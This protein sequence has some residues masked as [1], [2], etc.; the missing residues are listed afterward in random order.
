MAPGSSDRLHAANE[1]GTR[2]G[3]SLTIHAPR[4]MPGGGGNTPAPPMGDAEGIRQTRSPTRRTSHSRFASP[5]G[6]WCGFSR[7]PLS[8]IRPCAAVW[9]WNT[10]ADVP[11]CATIRRT[12]PGPAPC[13]STPG[14]AASVS[15]CCWSQRSACRKP[16]TDTLARAGFPASSSGS[17]SSDRSLPSAPGDSGRP[18]W[19]MRGAGSAWPKGSTNGPDLSGTRLNPRLCS[20]AIGFQAYPGDAKCP[21]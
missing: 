15:A 13:D 10:Q 18:G 21:R 16:G 6:T 17:P 14:G 7:P 9:F 8:D 11:S 1:A 20:H 4:W 3:L 12:R 5:P 19:D 2:R